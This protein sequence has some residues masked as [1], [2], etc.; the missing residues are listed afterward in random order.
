[1]PIVCIGSNHYGERR[2]RIFLN[3]GTIYLQEFHVY[4]ENET[5]AAD[6]VGNFC[7]EYMPGLCADHYEVAELCNGETVDEYAEAHNMTC[8]GDHGVYITIAGMEEM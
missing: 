1:M 5:E 8:C 7:E 6:I 3:T 4:A 2:Y